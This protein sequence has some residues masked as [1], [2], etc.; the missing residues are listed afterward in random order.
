PAPSLEPSSKMAADEVV[1][2]VAERGDVEDDESYQREV[3]AEYD[4]SCKLIQFVKYGE[5]VFGTLEPIEP[6][7][8]QEIVDRLG[9]AAP[10]MQ[11]VLALVQEVDRIAN[12]AP[13]MVNDEL[14]R[15][16]ARFAGS[17]EPEQV[18][19]VAHAADDALD[20]EDAK[21]LLEFLNRNVAFAA[22]QELGT[23]G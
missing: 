13:G 18:V 20:A 14:R 6:Q 4:P 23:L 7:E 1:V 17:I 19:E 2:L 9:R 12:A 11:R 10:F 15:A 8:W 16:L 5:E 3:T 21:M 22:L